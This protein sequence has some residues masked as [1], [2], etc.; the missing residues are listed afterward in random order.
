MKIALCLSGIYRGSIDSNIRLFKYH[1]SDADIFMSTWSNIKAPNHIIKHEEPVISYH[2]YIE[3]LKESKAPKY[4]AYKNIGWNGKGQM[5]A[6]R[7]KHHTKQ[8]IAHALLLNEINNI[9]SYNLVIRLR[10]DTVLSRQVSFK[11]YLEKS[12]C[13]N[14]AIGFGTRLSRHKNFNILSEVPKIYPDGKQDVSQD[15]GWYLMDPMIIHKPEKFN[16][17]LVFSLNHSKQLLPAEYGWYQ[18]LSEPY[19]DDHISVYGGAQIE[20]YV[21]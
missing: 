6:D 1:F 20:R 21:V 13:E 3:C 4:Q 9:K 7:T 15:W 12:Y 17:D 8:I 18:V 19:G 5:N 11:Q 10:Y 16:S 14:R 2:P